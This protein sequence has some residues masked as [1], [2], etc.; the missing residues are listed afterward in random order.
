MNPKAGSCGSIVDLFA[1]PYNHH[2]QVDSGVLE[3]EC[4]AV[5]KAFFK[6]LRN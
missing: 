2:P 3:C 5:L 1:L 4:A 6:K